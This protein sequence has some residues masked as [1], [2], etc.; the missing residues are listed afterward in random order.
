MG[1]SFTGKCRHGV[2]FIPHALVDKAFGEFSPAACK[3]LFFLYAA[4]NSRSAPCIRVSGAQLVYGLRMDYKT[5]RAARRELESKGAIR[6]GRAAKA[7]APYEL[8]LVNPETEEP[9]PPEDGRPEIADYKPRKSKAAR[10][11]PQNANSRAVRATRTPALAKARPSPAQEESP[12]SGAARLDAVSQERPWC[13]HACKGTDL[14]NLPD[15]TPRCSTCHP[16]PNGFK[17][18]ASQASAPTAPTIS[19]STVDDSVITE[20]GLP[21][22]FDEF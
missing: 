13:C 6:C 1:Y 21:L 17:P 4:V 19:T 15:G 8:H 14:W 9:F 18:D 5:I 22:K 20:D 3:L 16:N 10:S 11:S 12:L 7:G 2:F